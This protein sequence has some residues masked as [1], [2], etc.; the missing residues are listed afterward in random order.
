MRSAVS[1]VLYHAQGP[2]LTLQVAQGRGRQRVSRCGAANE[3]LNL[4]DALAVDVH[5]L[6][7]ILQ[8]ADALGHGGGTRHR[9][10]QS[11]EVDVDG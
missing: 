10:R 5:W 4:V 1:A 7:S 3:E 8:P 6:A 9:A 11:V 2:R